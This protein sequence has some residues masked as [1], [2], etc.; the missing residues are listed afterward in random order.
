M[1]SLPTTYFAEKFSAFDPADPNYA[2][3]VVD[4]VLAEAQ[5]LEASDVHLQPGK[6]GLELKFRLDGVLIPATVF[7]PAVA[8]NVITRLKVLAELL[9]YYT[10]RPQE[11]RIRT[12]DNP[13]EMRVSTFP[14]LH[15]ERAVVRLFGDPTRYQYPPDLGLPPELLGRLEELIGETSGAII[16]SG[17]AGSGKTTTA[18]ACLREIAN[19]S[20]RARS[21][22]SLEDPIEVAVDGV[23]QSQ[24]HP[25]V[26]LDLASGLKFLLRHDPEVIFMGEIRDRSTAEAAFQAAL[27]G[28]LLLTTFHAGSA[29]ETLGRL[30]DMGLEP[31]VVRSGLLAVLNQRLVRRLCSCAQPSADP[32]AAL[33]LPVETVRL[34]VGCPECRGTGYRDRLLIA[35]LCVIVN[36]SL[37]RALLNR[38]D[39]AALEHLASQSGMTSC[40]Q[41]AVQAVRDGVTSPAEIRRVLGFSEKRRA[42]DDSPAR[43][44]ADTDASTVDRAE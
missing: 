42:H 11:G 5:A 4:A 12:P 39:T 27:T 18:Y 22:V 23:A 26:G 28:H 29:A 44:A 2:S 20:G 15:G 25:Q 24:V 19:K 1:P 14:T 21:L 30:L 40:W 16:I 7:P 34:P 31:Y 43:D 17:P 38:A 32:A 6:E 10:D 35:E 36:S 37:A 9:T 8:A 13:V 3:R 41:Y 33:G